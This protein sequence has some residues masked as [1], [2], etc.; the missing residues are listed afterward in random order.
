MN[1]TTIA[2]EIFR[3]LGE[4]SD[5]SI[6]SIVFWLT[7]NIGALNNHIGTTLTVESSLIVPELNDDQKVNYKILYAI[8]YYTRQVN[9]N[10]GAAAYVN[11]I[12]FREGNRT[13]RRA[14]KNEVA[15]TYMAI[16]KETKDGFFSMVSAY[17]MNLAVPL[18][19][20]IPNPIITEDFVDRPAFNRN[21]WRRDA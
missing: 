8:H 3:E 13:V 19:I 14:N 20:I 16:L 21:Y 1:P 9:R 5:V 10:L 12:E 4:P 7:S 17:K 6:P 2:D 18:Q 11:I 15:K